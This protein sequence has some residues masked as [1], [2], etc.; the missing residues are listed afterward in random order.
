[1]L[2][3]PHYR[4]FLALKGKLNPSVPGD[5]TDRVCPQSP[6]ATGAPSKTTSE[7]I[8]RPNY[9]LRRI[10]IKSCRIFADICILFFGRV[11][12]ALLSTN[13]PCP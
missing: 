6:K 3:D 5:A 1:M 2:A 4:N 13:L 7:Q 10:L 8:F 12:P 9:T 11:I